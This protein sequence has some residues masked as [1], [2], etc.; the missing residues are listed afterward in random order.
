M[1]NECHSSSLLC[2]VHWFG[3]VQGKTPCSSLCGCAR[4]RSPHLPSLVEVSGAVAIWKGRRWG[5]L[6][7]LLSQSL[8]V[9]T[10]VFGY[11]ALLGMTST[12]QVQLMFRDNTSLHNTS[13]VAGVNMSFPSNET[14]PIDCDPNYLNFAKVLFA[15][16]HLTVV[17]VLLYSLV[18]CVCL[19]HAEGHR[20]KVEPPI[21][22]TESPVHTPEAGCGTLKDGESEK[23]ISDS[24]VGIGSA[25]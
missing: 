8:V 24:N 17:A 7:L 19:V 9:L 21:I 10:L 13:G 2:R 15:L 3:A 25:D 14:S 18:A 22:T 11:T 12:N 1:V 5:V 16:G 20:R 4:T 23:T 6:V